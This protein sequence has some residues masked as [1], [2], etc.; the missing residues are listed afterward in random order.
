[1]NVAERSFFAFAEPVDP[2]QTPSVDGHEATLT[3][4]V[5]FAGFIVISI[6]IGRAK[7]T[8]FN[9]VIT[10]AAAVVTTSTAWPRSMRSS[11]GSAAFPI[12]L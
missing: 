4:A 5:S 7:R 12:R 3:A 1:M 8:Q 2:M 10:G 6:G 9:W 11:A